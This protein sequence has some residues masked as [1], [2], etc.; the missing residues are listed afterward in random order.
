MAVT[1]PVPEPI[2][3][4]PGDPELHKPPAVASLR[5]AVPPTYNDAG[6]V[7]VDGAADTVIDFV[8]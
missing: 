2:V 5:V 3:A 4:I 6:P 7:M 1:K 8:T